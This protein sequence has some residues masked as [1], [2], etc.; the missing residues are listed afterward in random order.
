VYVCVFA[1]V[2]MC[3][4]VCVR[5]FV[6]MWYVC[7]IEVVEMIVLGWIE[8]GCDV[9]MYVCGDVCVCVCVCV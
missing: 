3:A 7:K 5:A 4:Y 9:C 8:C 1:C 6:R 2:C